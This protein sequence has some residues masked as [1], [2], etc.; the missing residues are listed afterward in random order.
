MREMKI[1][2]QDDAKVEDIDLWL[3]SGPVRV[4]RTALLNHLL[5]AFHGEITN[6]E[7][8]IE[9]IADAIG[10]AVKIGHKTVDAQRF[11]Q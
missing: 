3:A 10:I 2:L 7:C 4:S 6:Q 5:E 9:T 8:T 11:G 1:R